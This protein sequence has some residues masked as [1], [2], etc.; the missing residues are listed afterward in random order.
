MEVCAFAADG[1]GFR[2]SWRA[3]GWLQRQAG[4]IA[5]A[6]SEEPKGGT[7][8]SCSCVVLVKAGQSSVSFSLCEFHVTCHVEFKVCVLIIRALNGLDLRYLK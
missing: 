6:G 7:S 1:A 3:G 5:A 4:W 2:P 8:W